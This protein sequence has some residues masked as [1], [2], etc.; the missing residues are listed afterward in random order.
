MCAAVRAASAPADARFP[1]DC[2]ERPTHIRRVELWPER[3]GE[4]QPVVLP[5]NA[6]PPPRGCL[7]FLVLT[8]HVDSHPG[9]S[10]GPPGFLR[11]GVPVGKYG[12]PD[13][14]MERY[15]RVSAQSIGQP[16]FDRLR[17]GVAPRR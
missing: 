11:L 16:V 2:P 5:Q 6:C 4:D 14:D 7:P 9:Q 1:T 17:H 8:E 12:A 3:C 10:Q 15:R 13:V